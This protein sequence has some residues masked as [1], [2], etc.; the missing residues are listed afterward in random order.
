MSDDQPIV[1]EEP[2]FHDL[3]VILE[4]VPPNQLTNGKN[5]GIFRQPRAGGSK[6]WFMAEPEIQLHCPHDNCN[7]VRFF[8]YKDRQ[9]I[10]LAW[11][12]FQFFYMTFQ[13]SN[14]QATEKTFSL[15]VKLDDS[16]GSNGEIY[17][18]G[19]LPT[20]G[21]PV[22]ARVIKL[23]GP[24][25]EMFLRGR[26]CE[27]QGLGVGAFVYYRRVV[28]NQKSR[29]ISEI[30]KVAERIGAPEEKLQLLRASITEVQFSTA[31]SSI[32]D[33]V[34]ESL[35]I[36]G[37]NPMTLLYSALSEGVHNLTDEECLDIAS[38]IRVV[39]TELSERLSQALKDEAELKNALSKLMNRN[40]A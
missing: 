39:L 27:N 19:E 1:H 6:H 38:S 21:P 22:P 34:P 12:D 7:G 5:V 26:R 20:Y 16:R 28:E 30:L 15:A 17:K 24:D 10:R 18:F 8:R 32:R 25:R 14:C 31:M 9:D 23:I 35:L 37:Y 4:S 40:K 3:P 33:A 11:G 2:I 13:C 36:N 29:I